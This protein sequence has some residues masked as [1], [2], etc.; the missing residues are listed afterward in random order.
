MSVL[1]VGMSYRS[2]P[3]TF[4]E[5][6]SMD[7]AARQATAKALLARGCIAEVMIVSTCNRLEVYAVS[8][9]FHTG[10]NDIVEVLQ[11]QSDVD[12]ADLRSYL[13]VRNADA[14]AEHLMRVVSGLDSMVLGEQ[15]IIG[16]VRSAYQLAST[17]GTLGQ[18]LHGL[19]QAALRCGKRVHT[20]TAIDEAGSSMVTYA[21]DHALRSMQLKDLAGK[22]A[23]ILGAGAMAS[24]AA[25]HLGKLGVSQL[26]LSNRTRSKA[27]RLAEHAREAGVAA[28]VIDFNNRH[29][30]LGNVDL[31]ISATGANFYTIT[32]QT[33]SR[34]EQLQRKI[35]LVDLSMPRDIDDAVL[36]VPGVELINIERLRQM[37]V[38]KASAQRSVHEQVPGNT[39]VALPDAASDIMAAEQAAVAIVAEELAAFSSAQ[40]VRDVA[41]AVTALRQHANAIVAGE[42]DRL[43]TRVPDMDGDTYDEVTTAVHRIVEKLL[44]QPTVRVKQLAAEEGSVSYD[45]ALQALFGLMEEPAV[46]VNVADLPSKEQVS[47]EN[48]RI[49]DIRRIS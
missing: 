12:M 38:E 10:V 23:L 28:E 13:Y 33:L 27:E 24:L 1:V 34:A 4:L 42:L 30:A 45:T 5:Q 39:L 17:E 48:H 6:L 18:A 31:A 47:Q 25:S 49:E 3:V 2:A 8:S 26:V 22:R 44:H 19:V 43:Q 11:A 7:D 37:Q 40:R 41:P 15:Q 21:M 46:R 9:S 16:Q 20:E 29:M 36:Q 14:A 35:V 32:P